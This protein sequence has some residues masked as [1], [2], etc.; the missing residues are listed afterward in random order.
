MH[1]HVIHGRS[2]VG[3]VLALVFCVM[4]VSRPAVGQQWPAYGADKAGTKYSPLDQI[5]RDTVHDLQVVWRQST[6]PDA[7]RQGNTTRA[8]AHS[9]NTPLM[10]D[11][12]LYVSTGLGTVAALDATSGEV[13][14]YD[15]GTRGRATA[16]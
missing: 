16:R 7:V 9:Q 11:G 5:N 2:G 14:W 15:G 8:P 10:V 6:I 1:A 4:G 3:V 13:V 12:L